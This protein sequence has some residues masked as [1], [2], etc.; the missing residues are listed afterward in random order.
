MENEKTSKS[1][2]IDRICIIFIPVIISIVSFFTINHICNKYGFCIEVLD[3]IED[4]KVMLSVWG[5]LLG[6]LITAV[7]I[8]LTLG[9]GKFLGILKKTGHFE[10][11]LL[12]YVVCCIH[13]LIAV[14]VAIVCVF[15]R[16]WSM[17]IFSVMCAATVDTILMVA[18]CL[19]FL[20]TLVVRIND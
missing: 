17:T 3:G 7:S 14:V 8:L 19:F 5:T 9:D 2:I 18:I 10:T 4:F 16:I 6:F 12:S 11:I 20:F 13:L 15:G 1:I